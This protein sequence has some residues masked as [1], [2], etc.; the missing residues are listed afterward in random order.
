MLPVQFGIS[1]SLTFQA[2]QG[3][4]FLPKL[5]FPQMS[6]ALSKIFAHTYF[7]NEQDKALRHSKGGIF[8][9]FLQVVFK[10]LE[11]YALNSKE[12]MASNSERMSNSLCGPYKPLATFHN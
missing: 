11:I 3:S 2:T 7:F 9:Y 12:N 8:L 6:N 4:G 1:F 10:E 5:V